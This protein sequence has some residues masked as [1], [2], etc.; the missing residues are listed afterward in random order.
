MKK[1]YN[2]EEFIE[3]DALYESTKHNIINEFDYIVIRIKED[4]M[5]DNKIDYYHTFV[6][7]NNE[8]IVRED[9]DSMQS[10]LKSLDCIKK[11]ILE[12]I[13][14]IDVSFIELIFN[15]NNNFNVIMIKKD[16]I[17]NNFNDLIITNLI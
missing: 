10:K 17:K 9:N 7:S 12:K 5:Y 14:S 6:I 13:N 2:F 11:L 4:N 8:F 3:V 16:V 1:K 15:H